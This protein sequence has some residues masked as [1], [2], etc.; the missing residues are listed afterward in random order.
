[1][2]GMPDH[3]VDAIITDPP[4]A[5]TQC[6]WDLAVP[7][8]ELWAQY[9]RVAKPNAPIVV[10]SAQPFTSKL[11]MSQPDLYRYLWYWEKE[12]G[13]NFFRTGNQPLRVIEEICVFAKTSKYQQGPLKLFDF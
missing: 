7:F 9:L 4:Y 6:G 11:I 10:F 5:T 1:M 3:S 12:K 2:A 8:D 13:T